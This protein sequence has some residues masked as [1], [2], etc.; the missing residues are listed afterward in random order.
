[1]SNQRVGSRFDRYMALRW[2]NMTLDL[3]LSNQESKE[4]LLQLKEWLSKE[5]LGKE[6]QRKTL[7][8]ANHMWL[9][10]EDQHERLRDWV[11]NGGLVENFAYRPLFHYGLA[12]NVFPLFWEVCYATGR[13]LNLQ[14]S[15]RREDIYQRMREIHSSP[16][17]I[18]TATKHV[19]QTLVDWGLLNV[20]SR[21]ISTREIMIE[22]MAL[23]QW[24]VAVLLSARKTN[25]MPLEDLNKTPEL[26]GIRFQDV[27]SAI[28]LSP[29]LRI[30]Y[31]LGCEMVC[32]I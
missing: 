19:I 25:K 16:V 7:A 31:G 1:M 29:N 27:R 11:I 9:I 30:E 12:L 6:T 15:C 10:K 24:L 22:D 20:N 2:M 18:V 21:E 26:L 3:R 13:I 32:Y 5:I 14:P 23:T 8:Q 17:S 28:R 4:A